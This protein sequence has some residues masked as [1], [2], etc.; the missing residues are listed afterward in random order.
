MKKKIIAIVIVA[1]VFVGGYLAY[2]HH[3]HV[4]AK[5]EAE[6]WYQKNIAPDKTEE[7]TVKVGSIE[8]TADDMS[9]KQLF[10]MKEIADTLTKYIGKEFPPSMIYRTIAQGTVVV[11]M[12]DHKYYFQS[13]NNDDKGYVVVILNDDETV[14]KNVEYSTKV[15]E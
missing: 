4:V 8:Q 2:D 12:N 3:K 10:S 14:I 1:A 13:K 9:D 5:Q 11:Y 7:L 6:K 15:K